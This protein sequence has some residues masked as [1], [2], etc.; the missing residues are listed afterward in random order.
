MERR[1]DYGKEILE[2]YGRFDASGPA[3]QD[4]IDLI[5]SILAKHCMAECGARSIFSSLFFFFSLV[6][7]DI[8]GISKVID[9]LSPMRYLWLIFLPFICTC[10][11]RAL[12]F[13][14]MRR[15]CF[16]YVL[17]RL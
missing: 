7:R 17:R 4:T 13:F 15:V 2:A 12:S 16:F 9:L 6:L 14:L 1:N 5:N 10:C 8:L 3:T 11:L